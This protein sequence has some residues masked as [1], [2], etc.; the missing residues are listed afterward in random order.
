MAEVKSKSKRLDGK[1][2][3]KVIVGYNLTLLRKDG[4]KI[5]NIFQDIDPDIW[6]LDDFFRKNY[7]MEQLFTINDSLVKFINDEDIKKQFMSSTTKE[8]WTNDDLFEV[9]K[10]VIKY[11]CHKLGIDPMEVLRNVTK[12]NANQVLEKFYKKFVYYKAYNN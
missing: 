4:V 1:L 9:K 12:K 11:M 6:S 10:D 2:A 7:T 8:R 5:Y 3:L